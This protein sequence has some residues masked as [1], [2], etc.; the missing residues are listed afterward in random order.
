M[1]QEILEGEADIIKGMS[2]RRK[3]QEDR[4][5][6]VEGDNKEVE[7]ERIERIDRDDGKK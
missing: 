2:M 4:E 6:K 5:D 7:K 1:H 3:I